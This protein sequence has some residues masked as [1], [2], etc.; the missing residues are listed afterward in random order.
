MFLVKKINDIFRYEVIKG[1]VIA[2]I[3]RT[4]GAILAF[5]FNLIVAKKIGAEGAGLFF[6]VFTISTIM[7]IIGRFGLDNIVIRLMAINL[8]VNNWAAIKG[9]YIKSFFVVLVLTVFITV[10]VFCLSP[11]LGDYVFKQ[12]GFEKA[13]QYMSLCIVPSSLLILN[14]EMYKALKMVDKSFFFNG[15][16]VPLLTLIIIV[17]I[18]DK[19]EVNEVIWSYNI[20]VIISLLCSLIIWE[21]KVI[22]FHSVKGCYEI[23][24]LLMDGSH[25]LI[26]NIFSLLIRWSPIIFLGIW[27]SDSDIGL[28]GMASKTVMVL[29][30]F[31]VSINSIII[32]K[33]AS[34]YKEKKIKEI[35]RVARNSSRLLVIASSPLLILFIFF[36]TFVMSIY[37]EEFKAANIFLVLLTF[38]EMINAYTGPVGELL[39]MTGNEKKVKEIVIK[40]SILSLVLNALMIYAYGVIGAAITTSI[41]LGVLNIYYVYTIKKMHGIWV[42]PWIKITG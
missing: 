24:S 16:L 40:I 18:L 4:A 33:F 29:S 12:D 39:M 3:M 2:F 14:S 5:I 1:F 28:Y 17:F 21:R 27:C 11:L 32:P 35:E 6:L 30:I 41:S 23:R 9:V 22:S 20:S 37:G 8:V 36:S 25:L 10:S 26:M 7:S 34:L 38:G 13:M 19:C 42:L 15:I 31:S